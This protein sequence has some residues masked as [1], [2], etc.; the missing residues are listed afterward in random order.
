[1]IVIF[2]LAFIYLLGNVDDDIN[3]T[4][5]ANTEVSRSCAATLNNEMWVF[6]GWS[7]TRQVNS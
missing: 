3:F 2:E 7:K 1:M 6:G 4:F 5:E